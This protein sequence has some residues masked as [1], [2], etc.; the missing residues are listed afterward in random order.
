MAGERYL[1]AARAA[2][3]Q[4]FQAAGFG[5]NA[6]KWFLKAPEMPGVFQWAWFNKEWHAAAAFCAAKGIDVQTAG[7]AVSEASGTEN[8]NPPSY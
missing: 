1:A 5:A 4:I 7:E 3:A 6:G 2:G 8:P